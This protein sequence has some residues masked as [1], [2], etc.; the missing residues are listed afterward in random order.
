MNKIKPQ[1]HE[2]PV[3]RINSTSSAARTTKK[4]RR[5]F[6]YNFFQTR[7]SISIRI[8]KYASPKKKNHTYTSFT[9]LTNK[10]RKHSPPSENQPST[11]ETKENEFPTS[12]ERLKPHSFE[13]EQTKSRPLASHGHHHLTSSSG[14]A[15]CCLALSRSQR[16]QASF[17][18]AEQLAW[19]QEPQPSQRVTRARSHG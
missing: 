3:Y 18:L 13:T 9:R 10:K 4:N 17:L 8:R 16:L 14:G 2:F 12:L 11:T 1:K 5:G 15:G 6:L 7:L 19:Q